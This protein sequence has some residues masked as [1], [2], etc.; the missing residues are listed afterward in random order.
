M[1][2]SQYGIIKHQIF[3]QNLISITQ[4]YQLTVARLPKPFNLGKT[5]SNCY[6]PVCGDK[7]NYLPHIC[8]D[9]FMYLSHNSL[10]NDKTH[11]MLQLKFI[12]KKPLLQQ[13][14]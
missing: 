8:G 6:F 9:L 12:D 14:G 4:I 1:K 5:D 10:H 2:S 7:L 13:V 11:L 3:V